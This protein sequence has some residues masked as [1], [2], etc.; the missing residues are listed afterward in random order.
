M[1][2]SNSHLERRLSEPTSPNETTGESGGETIVGGGP[3]IVQRPGIFT[4]PFPLDKPVGESYLLQNRMVLLI[5]FFFIFVRSSFR[6]LVL[7]IK[8]EMKLSLNRLMVQQVME[9]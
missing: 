3:H 9:S 7:V 8:Q 2:E 4:T 1:M 6:K 5:L